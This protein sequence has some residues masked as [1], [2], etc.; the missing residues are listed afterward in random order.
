MRGGQSV[1]HIR[2][3]DCPPRD[4]HEEEEGKRSET[5]IVVVGHGRDV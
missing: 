1:T 4:G 5:E 2:S 3:A